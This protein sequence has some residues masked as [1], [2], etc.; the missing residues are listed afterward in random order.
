M[1]PSERPPPR[2]SLS[3]G[4]C[5]SSPVSVSR[6]SHGRPPRVIHPMYI[7][8]QVYLFLRGRIVHASTHIS[9]ERWMRGRAMAPAVRWRALAGG[10]ASSSDLRVAVVTRGLS[11]PR[12][13]LVFCTESWSGGRVGRPTGGS[14]LS[15]VVSGRGAADLRV[16]LNWHVAKLNV[17]RGARGAC[18][19]RT[20]P[21]EALSARS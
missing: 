7:Q 19:R 17:S 5:L 13:W 9:T 15:A 3:G 14:L 18:T 8:Y 12:V 16:Q 20:A 1:A 11:P 2:G 21:L 4:L 6:S 10:Q